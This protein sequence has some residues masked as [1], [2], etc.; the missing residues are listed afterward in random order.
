MVKKRCKVTWKKEFIGWLVLDWK[1]KTWK[2]KKTRRRAKRKG[3][4]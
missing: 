2:K 4:M 1:P 3:I